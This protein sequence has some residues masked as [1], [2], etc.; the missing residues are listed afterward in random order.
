MVHLLGLVSRPWHRTGHLRSVS[1]SVISARDAGQTAL[2]HYQSLHGSYSGFPRPI[3]G[4]SVG[5]ESVVIK[6]LRGARRMNPPRP[7]TVPLWDIT[8]I[9]RAL[10]GP[11]FEPLQSSSLRVLS[12]MNL[13][14]T[15]STAHHPWTTSPIMH[16]THTFPSTITPITQLSPF[17]H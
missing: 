3:A 5:R 15:H 13:V 9:L 17:T 7:R 10:K 16:C 11:P 6:V 1:G 14:A 8:T 4:R 12:V 2:I